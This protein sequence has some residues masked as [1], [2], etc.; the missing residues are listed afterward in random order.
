[1]KDPEHEE[2]RGQTAPTERWPLRPCPCGSPP[3]LDPAF[4]W[5]QSGCT[6]ASPRD[7]EGQSRP[8]TTHVNLHLDQL[9]GPIQKRDL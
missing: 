4:S 7:S 8:R 1:M 2:R 3:R 5:A 9:R 6:R